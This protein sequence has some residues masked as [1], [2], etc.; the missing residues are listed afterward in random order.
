MLDQIVVS[1]KNEE[2]LKELTETIMNRNGLHYKSSQTDEETNY[3]RVD[4]S[5]NTPN[6][7]YNNYKIELVVSYVNYGE[8]VKINEKVV[9]DFEEF[10]VA[11]SEWLDQSC[12]IYLELTL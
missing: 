5:Y 11:R 10:F 9:E 12:R 8:Y 3:Y 7:D 1:V 6:G 2:D 4:K